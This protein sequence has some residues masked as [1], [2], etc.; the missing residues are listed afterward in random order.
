V[1]ARILYANFA[2]RKLYESKFLIGANSLI[3]APTILEILQTSFI[4][5]KTSS[6]SKPPGSG[7]PVAGIMLASNPSTSKVI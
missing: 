1:Y 2:T 6:Q 5:G 3:S 7:V 4:I